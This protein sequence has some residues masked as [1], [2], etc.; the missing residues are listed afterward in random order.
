MNNY[1]AFLARRRASAPSAGFTVAESALHPSLF[2]FQRAA[3]THALQLGRAALFE[4]TGLGKSRQILEWM[5]LVAAHTGSRC[6]L[7]VP[8]AVAHQFVRTE[9]LALGI[10]LAYCR[11]QAEV[12]ASG[13]APPGALA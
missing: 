10:E 13:C 4:D 9:A 11:S 3:I 6:L 1:F 8:L 5:R 7:L 12:D 2:P